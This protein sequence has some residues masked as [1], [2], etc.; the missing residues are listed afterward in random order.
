MTIKEMLEQRS[1]N[2][3][4]C[5]KMLEVA[6][7]EGRNLN[8]DED[9]KY[10]KLFNEAREMKEKAEAEHRDSVRMKDLE[11]AEAESREMLPR[12]TEDVIKTEQRKQEPKI[13]DLRSSVCGDTRQIRIEGEKA[14]DGYNSAFRKYLS[15]GINALSYDEVRALSKDTDTAG[16]YLS[17]PMQFMAELIKSVDN[18]TFMRQIGRVLPPLL[19]AESLGVPSLDADPADP[20]WTAE[21]AAG[22]EDSTMAFGKREL[23]P[24]PLAQYIKVS[25]TLLRRS[26]IGVDSIV[27]DRLAYKMG[28]VQ[29][30]AFLNGSGANQPLGIFTASANGI[31]T[32]QDVSTGNTATA[33]TVD[34]LKNA[35][36]NL[37]GQYRRNA[38]WVF[39]R[40]A[41]KMLSKLKDGEGR[42]LWENSVQVGQPDRLL[43]LPV[44]ESEYAP[45]TFTS[46]LYVG[47]VGD[48]SY[49]WVVDALTM[50]IQYV[51]QLYAATNQDAF[52]AR[53]ELDGMP[54][55]AEAFA[56]VKL[57]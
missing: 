23:R 39:H 9:A 33:F 45:N 49:Y 22:S 6:K 12:R 17:A 48:F 21:I 51:D 27:R 42:Y 2:L 16:G 32:S 11:Q 47:V 52:F 41:V 43:N 44:Y 37:K 1:K 54:V 5:K 24:Y 55:L 13:V 3:A 14:S 50:A 15:R 28:V 31:T 36:Y 19:S 20:T 26:A 53:T 4:D 30:N 25:K 29:E 46:A 38:S 34:G 7:S 10:T 40:D 57:G 8:A 35:L 18:L 56:R